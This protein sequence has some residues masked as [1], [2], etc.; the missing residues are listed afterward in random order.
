MAEKNTVYSV[1]IDRMTSMNN[2][3]LMNKRIFKRNLSIL[4]NQLII[5]FKLEHNIHTQKTLFLLK[6]IEEKRTEL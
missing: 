4:R 5:K 6:Y 2:W 1:R 3:C